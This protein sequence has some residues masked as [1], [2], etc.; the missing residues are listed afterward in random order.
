VSKP[1]CTWTEQR[2]DS[3]RRCSSLAC[4]D[5]PVC[6]SHLRVWANANPWEMV[7]RRSVLAATLRTGARWAESHGLGPGPWV[8]LRFAAFI[9]ANAKVIVIVGRDEA[10][11]MADWYTERL[12][13]CAPAVRR[14]ALALAATPLD[15]QRVMFA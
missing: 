6:R 8:E 13:P 3:L 2:G 14:I 15:A 1:G 11:V 5:F 9:G 12:D 4:H 7:K 10:A